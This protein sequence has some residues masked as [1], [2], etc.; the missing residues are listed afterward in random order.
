MPLEEVEVGIRNGVRK[1][2]IDTDIRMA[3][4]GA[5][6]KHFAQNP[7]SFDIRGFHEARDRGDTDDCA[8]ER[9]ERFG[10]AGNASKLEP[11]SLSDMAA[12]YAEGLLAQRVS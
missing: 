5:L 4:T 8:A 7:S 11:V 6:R 2:N 1:V 3:F 12:R 9:F 10:C